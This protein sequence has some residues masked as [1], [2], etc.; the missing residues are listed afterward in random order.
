MTAHD[1]RAAQLTVCPAC[2]ATSGAR[3]RNWAGDYAAVPC[4]ARLEVVRA[5]RPVTFGTFVDQLESLVAC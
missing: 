4:A 3:C 2:G 5:P 1:H